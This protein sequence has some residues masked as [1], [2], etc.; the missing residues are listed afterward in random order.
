VPSPTDVGAIRRAGIAAAIATA[1]LGLA[2]RF[3][4]AYRVRA[5]YPRRNPPRVTPTDFGMAYEPMTVA[6][7][8]LRLPAW[9]IPARGGAPGPA[10]V[11]VHGWE[12]AR[13]RTLPMALFLHAAGFHCLTF[14]IRGHG[15]NPPE[16]LPLSAGEFGADA[17]AACRAAMTRPEVTVTA[18][19]GHS[20][21]GIGAILAAAAEPRIAAVVATSSP[22]DPYRLT[23]QTFRLARLPIPDPIAY[24]LAWLTT[25][26]YL[27]PR[28]H[29]VEDVSATAA[30]ARYTGPILLAHGELDNVVP[31]SHMTRLAA[32][33]RAGR[34][35][36]PD[37]APVESLLVPGGQHS[38]LYEDMG[39]RR[40]VARF[41]ATALGSPA[42]PEAA[43]EL[44]AHV[45]AERIPDGEVRF[46][47]AEEAYGGFRTLAQVAL[48]GAT[49]RPTPGP[50]AIEEPVPAT[51]PG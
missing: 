14:D 3:A 16:E 17:L 30:V 41:L 36:R 38:W 5:G 4:L 39:Y 2:Y 22:A 11:L 6:S 9:F 27:R 46:A 45:P 13:D 51:P 48:P 21:G 1:P 43:G 33:A 40:T 49:R 20:M 35:G 10:V 19:S 42:D 23:R 28:G 18:V 26:V 50:D 31:P 8:G 25:R 44:A 47:A 29:D 32:A 24:P 37:A 7:D 12:S 15:A 34:G